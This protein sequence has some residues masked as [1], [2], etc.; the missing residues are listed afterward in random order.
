MTTTH[1]TILTRPWRK[2]SRSTGGNDCVEV[3]QA[4]ASCLVRDSKNPDDAC[5]TV[6]PQAWA[7]FIGDIKH[8]AYGS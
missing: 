8:G 4:G 6:R 1:D 5:L 3:A 7:A 2:S